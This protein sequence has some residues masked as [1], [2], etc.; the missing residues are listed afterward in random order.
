MPQ[1]GTYKVQGMTFSGMSG[2]NVRIVDVPA[3]TDVDIDSLR[4]ETADISGCKG[5]ECHGRPFHLTNYPGPT[6]LV[7][8]NIRH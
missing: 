2:R 1:A 8:G 6:D 7:F 3:R 5:Q 4:S